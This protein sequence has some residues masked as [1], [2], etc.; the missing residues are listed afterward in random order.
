MLPHKENVNGIGNSLFSNMAVT[1]QLVS[2]MA[3]IP[4]HN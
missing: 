3:E 2:T 1:V 4:N